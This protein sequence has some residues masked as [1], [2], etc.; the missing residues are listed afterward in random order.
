[1]P[2]PKLFKSKMTFFVYKLILF[3]FQ[4]GHLFLVWGLAHGRSSS[5]YRLLV[6]V[7]WSALLLYCCLIAFISSSFAILVT[8][9]MT[10]PPI[11]VRTYPECLNELTPSLSA[12]VQDAVPV[13]Q[14][15]MLLKQAHHSFSIVPQ[16][17]G[18]PNYTHSE[19]IYDALYQ[20]IHKHPNYWFDGVF[21]KNRRYAEWT[22]GILGTLA[23]M[24]RQRGQVQDCLDILQVDAQVLQVYQDLIQEQATDPE[25]LECCL[26]LTYKYHV[27]NI[28]ANAQLGNSQVAVDSFRK[29]IPVELEHPN[30]SQVM[31]W[32]HLLEPFFEDADNITAAQVEE[33]SDEQIWFQIKLYTDEPNQPGGNIHYDL[34]ICD[35]CGDTET[36]L[37]NYKCCSACKVTR[38]CSKECQRAHW[39]QGGHKHAC[40]H[41]DCEIDH[42]E[43]KGTAVILTNN[44][45]QTVYN[46]TKTPVNEANTKKVVPKLVNWLYDAIK[47]QPE[48]NS[49]SAFIGCWQ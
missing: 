17:T 3:R 32:I 7:L 20:D 26:I 49:P 28:N 29:V 38:Y 18:Q 14:R 15:I 11:T 45:S 1:M 4:I 13:M 30:H 19:A 33:L 25:E 43:I 44:Y 39:T 9:T 31:G 41:V 36:M 42:E 16:L 47:T 48:L 27:I 40:G 24:R 35:Y 2:L 23:T 10:A 34:R 5:T 22:V 12:L 37:G 8:L 6:H 21:A 46:F